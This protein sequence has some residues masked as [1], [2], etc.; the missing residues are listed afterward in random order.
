[1]RNTK[2][3]RSLECVIEEEKLRNYAKDL[4]DVTKKKMRME[5]QKRSF[6]KQ[7]GA[8]LEACSA[9]INLLS[10]KVSTGKEYRDIE[11][12]IEYDWER[13]EKA[14]VRIDT[15]DVVSTDIIKED[16]LQE[17]LNLEE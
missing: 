14:I 10:D 2:C 11:C 6:T 15:G 7:I 12:A 13:K 17:H 1:M 9:Q 8:E 3:T 16:E 4:A 5:D